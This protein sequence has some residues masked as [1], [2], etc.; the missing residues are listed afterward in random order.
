MTKLLT[1]KNTRLKN[2]NYSDNGWYFVTICSKGR[3]KIFGEH[4]NVLGTG[5]APVRCKNNIELSKIGKIID[6]Q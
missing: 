4:E 1:R 2:Y 5:L 6:K 3:G